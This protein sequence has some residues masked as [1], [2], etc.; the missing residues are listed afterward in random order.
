MMIYFVTALAL[1]VYLAIVF[2]IGA[3]LKL[4]GAQVWI[5]RLLLAVIGLIA[6]GVCLYFLHR[7]NK[8]TDDAA[9]PAHEGPSD[10][11]DF[12]LHEAEAK[13]TASRLGSG[14]RYSKLPV[15]FLIGHPGS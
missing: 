7:K 13:L 6:A 8:S 10:D 1:L 15:V 14:A 2:L 4:S 12:S 5:F 3:M 11:L 9:A